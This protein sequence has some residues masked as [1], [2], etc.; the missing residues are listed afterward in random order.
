MK[1]IGEEKSSDTVPLRLCTHLL[2]ITV[3]PHF[4]TLI[5]MA[6]VY[7]VGVVLLERAVL[8][9]R[10]TFA[11]KITNLK[12]KIHISYLI[13]FKFRPFLI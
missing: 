12:K 1:K 8:L 6:E 11:A 5:R 4:L 9:E 3:L 13:S 2:A 7:T 10:R